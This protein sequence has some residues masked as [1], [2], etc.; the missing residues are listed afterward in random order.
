M[1]QAVLVFDQHGR[2][3]IRG[4][5]VLFAQLLAEP[6]LDRAKAHVVAAVALFST[7]VC[8]S[9]HPVGIAKLSGAT[10]TGGHDVPEVHDESAEMS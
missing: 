3:R 1:D 10:W 7:V 4:R 5:A 9:W 2:R 6:A 8:I